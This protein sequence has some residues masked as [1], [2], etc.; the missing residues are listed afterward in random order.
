MKFGFRI[1]IDCLPNHIQ[2]KDVE[3]VIGTQ[4]DLWPFSEH[5]LTGK[6]RKTFLGADAK[7]NIFLLNM[8]W[9]TIEYDSETKFQGLQAHI[10]IYVCELE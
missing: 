3:L 6:T 7:F 4:G 8:I 1:I 2:Q 10:K 5:F 9:E